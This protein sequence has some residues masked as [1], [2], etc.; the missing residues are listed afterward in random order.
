MIRK[1]KQDWSIGQV[2]KVGFLS[3]VVKAAIATPGDGRPDAYILSNQAGTQ[4]YKFVPH[5]G[6]EKI[7]AQVA[8]ALGAGV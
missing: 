5:Q 1:T 3:M 6:V 4:M 8:R 2:V 7:S